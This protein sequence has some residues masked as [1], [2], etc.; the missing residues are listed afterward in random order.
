MAPAPSKRPSNGGDARAGDRWIAAHLRGEAPV[1][2]AGAGALL[3]AS[4]VNFRTG[5]ELKAAIEGIAGSGQPRAS[6]SIALFATGA[7]ASCIRTILFDST[8]ER[9]RA[10]LAS[11]VFL[12]RLTT[13][14]EAEGESSPSEG[15]EPNNK[16][17]A[18]S[19]DSD[20]A[21]VADLVPKLQNV[22][23]YTASV[24]GGTYAMFRASWKLGL[25]VWPLLVAGSARGARAGAKKAGKAAQKLAEKR[26]EALGFAEERLQHGDIVRWFLRAKPEAEEYQRRCKECSD[27]AAKSARGRGC[28]HLVVDMASKGMLLGL[29]QL[30]SYLVQ[31]GELTA[32]ELTSFFFHAMFLGLGLYGLVGLAPEIAVGRGAA[33]RLAGLV[34]AADLDLGKVA[35]SVSS[36]E[37]L[38]IT[39]DNVSFDH[40]TETGTREVLRGFSLK[41]EPGTTCALIG[42]SGSG[43]STALS[44]LLRD[45]KPQEG[46][47][48]IGDEDV[49]A[50]ALPDLRSKLAIAP[51]NNAL[52]GPSVADALAFGLGSGSSSAKLSQLEEAAKA[53]CAHDFVLARAGG[54][55]SAV[56]RGGCLL[57]GGERQRLSLARAMVRKA[58]ILVLDEPTSALDST[59]AASLAEAILAPR[60]NRP[61]TLIVTHSLA[62]IKRCDQVAVLSSEGKIVQ[63]GPY[64]TLAADKS[65]ALSK[66]MKDGE[67][68]DDASG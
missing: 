36:S 38:S 6:K 61:T 7:A 29:C 40:R 8:T 19:D 37:P 68:I 44:L 50:M 35:D 53:A 57:S 42:A 14:P 59:T 32:G 65:G 60:S 39:F 46:R 24:V 56:G 18:A 23:R 22:V 2:F 20:V 62:L 27:L 43:K 5:P 4:F 51:Q 54:Y 58:P 17:S 3:I 64:A 52:L 13:E 34:A 49:Q 33:K 9:L 31:K 28:A 55:Q 10:S 41:I 11:E 67:L 15:Q 48:L 66:I 30:G 21:L 16:R 26:E 1:L 45:G 12:A 25:L 63:L 47:I